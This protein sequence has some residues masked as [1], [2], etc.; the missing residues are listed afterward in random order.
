V[1]VGTKELKN[2]LSYYL[3]LVRDGERVIVCDRGKVVAELRSVSAPT[4]N[5]EAA[6]LAELA[7]QGL[8][9]LGRGRLRDFEPARPCR[10]RR[11]STL[12]IQDR[13]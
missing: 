2:R 8:L 3:R 5:D 13:D 1:N 4:D 12:V 9:V 11:L 7:K 10:R 6:A